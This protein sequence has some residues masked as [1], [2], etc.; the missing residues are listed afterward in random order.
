MLE[1]FKKE[2]TND[3]QRKKDYNQEL[4]KLAQETEDKKTE[5]T[6]LEKEIDELQKSQSKQKKD[7]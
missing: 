6:N 5:L 2:A 1:A 4:A 7:H 3:E